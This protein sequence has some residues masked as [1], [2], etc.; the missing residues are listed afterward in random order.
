MLLYAQMCPIMYSKNKTKQQ[1]DIHS[2]ATC[3]EDGQT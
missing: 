3:F 2:S 1:K